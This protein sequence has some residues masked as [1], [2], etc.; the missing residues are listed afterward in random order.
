P[1]LLNE[2]LTYWEEKLQG[3]SPINFPTDFPRPIEQSIKGDCLRFSI[4]QKQREQLQELAREQDVTLFMLLLS[5]FKVLLYKYNSQDDICVGSPIANRTQAE[6]EPLIGFF[7]NT[8]ALRSDLSENP[9]FVDL[10][11]QVKTTTLEAYM[12]QAVPF[13]KIVD[14]VEKNRDRSRSPIF[15]VMFKLQEA[16]PYSQVNLGDVQLQ[17]E[18]FETHT[19]MFDLTFNVSQTPSGMS[20]EIQYCTD[21]FLRSRIERM[22]DHFQNLLTAILDSPQ[23]QIG[24]FSILTPKERQQV[25]VDFNQTDRRYE[26]N[27]RVDV[28]FEQQAARTPD[29]LAILF[30]DTSMT[31]R[32]LNDRANQLANYLRSRGLSEGSLVAICLDRSLE[33]M[34]SLL[35]ILKAGAAYVPL[36]PD[37]PQERIDYI[38]DNAQASYVI[39]T[40][41][42]ATFFNQIENTSVVLI[43]ED[44]PKIAEA[45]MQKPQV[46]SSIDDLM[47]VIYTSGSTGRPKGVMNRHRGVV[48]RLL[49]GKNQFQL[50]PENDVLIQK[51]TVC[52]DISVWELFWP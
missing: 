44:W 20:V 29:Q 51:T 22:R 35:G 50:D 34:V 8:L 28:L 25:L 23:T 30:E 18:S 45:S 19:T 33:M 2:K 31:Y 6:V 1:Q 13:E 17:V 40:K 10:L 3:V 16:L 52:F 27:E 14:R 32:T 38:I 5:V 12:H 9:R 37:Y 26:A 21:L 42:Y 36:D 47:Y 11:A 4:D 39:C 41:N 24:H 49:W 46:E 48:N 43:N 7:V 15:Q